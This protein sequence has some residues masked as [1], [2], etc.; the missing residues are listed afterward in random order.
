MEHNPNMRL[1][2]ASTSEMFGS[3]PPPQDEESPMNPVSPYA[4]AKL[5]AHE[6]YVKGYRNK[7][8]LFICSGILFNHESPR[9]GE[10]F[11]TRKITLSFAKISQGVQTHVELGNLNAKRDWGFAGDYVDVM[12]RMLQQKKP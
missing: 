7:H 4:I 12:H 11:V 3:T 10:N 5:K 2:Q 6:D 9:R 8:G 1:Y